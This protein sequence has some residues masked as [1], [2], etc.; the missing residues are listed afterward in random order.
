[1]PYPIYN[2][3]VH[4]YLEKQRIIKQKKRERKRTISMNELESNRRS[5]RNKPP[6]T[7]RQ[8]QVVT[9]RRP[10]GATPPRPSSAPGRSSGAGTNTGG[11]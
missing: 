8:Q 3:S 5:R 7:P 11:Y 4:K 10:A 2:S 6:R 1:M 9:P